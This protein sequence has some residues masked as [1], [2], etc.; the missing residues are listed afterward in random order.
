MIEPV[1]A[2]IVSEAPRAILEANAGPLAM[3]WQVFT[4]DEIN[5]MLV[6]TKNPLFLRML[7]Q[8]ESSNTN[9]ARIDS[10]GIMS[11]GIL[12]FNGT[13]TWDEFAP[14]AGVIGGTPMDPAAAI[15]VADW[16]ITHGHVA[17]W[18]CARITGII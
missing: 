7:I 2:A 6:G 18:S 15:K 10:N 4:Q 12:Q 8:C 13:G 17:R 1:Q 5:A 11:Y 16:M 14:Q 3:R 9:I